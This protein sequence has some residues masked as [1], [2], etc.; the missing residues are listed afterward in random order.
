MFQYVIKGIN[1]KGETVFEED[2]QSTSSFVNLSHRCWDLAEKNPS[3]I[4]IQV[5]IARPDPEVI[6]IKEKIEHLLQDHNGIRASAMA[7][8]IFDTFNIK[9]R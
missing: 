6:S 5:N 2:I 9:E 3:A 8:I 4:H 1:N 7:D